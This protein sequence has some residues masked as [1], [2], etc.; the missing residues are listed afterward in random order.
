MDLKSKYI[1]LLAMKMLTRFTGKKQTKCNALRLAHAGI[2]KKQHQQA[3]PN[4]RPK[5]AP[6]SFS[7][8]LYRSF[9][10]SSSESLELS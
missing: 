3:N 1:I 10:P 2:D 6:T 8:A 7:A 9:I 4:P 5:E